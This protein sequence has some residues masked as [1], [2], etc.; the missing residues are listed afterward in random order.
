MIVDKQ[1]ADPPAC[2]G[3]HD[4]PPDTGSEDMILKPAPRSLSSA[5][6]PP[7]ADTR[8]R[9]PISPSPALGACMSA[10]QPLSAMSIS[11]HG[12]KAGVPADAIRISAWVAWE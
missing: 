12:P 10:P 11:T 5:I 6:D 4:W 7:R 8:S 1:H 9:I 2:G 3:D